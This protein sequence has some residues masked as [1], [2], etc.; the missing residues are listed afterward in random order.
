MTENML[1]NKIKKITPDDEYHY[2]FGYYDLQPYDKSGKYHL[3]HRVKF[4]DR[5]PLDS[6]ICEI[7][8]I[9]I[10]SGRFIKVGETT[11][12]NF[13]QGAFLNWFSDTSVVYN[14]FINGELRAVVKDLNG[15]T[16]KVISRPLASLSEDK[17]WGLSINFARIFSFRPGYG[18]AAAI[19]EYSEENVPKDDG[20][21]IVDMQSGDS[22]LLISYADIVSKYP[23][24]PYTEKKLVINHVTFNPSATKFIMLLRNFPD[25]STNKRTQL[26]VVDFAKNIEKI[27]DY[28]VNSHYSWK[29]DDEFMIWSVLEQGKGVYF[30]NLKT[31]ERLKLGNEIL[32]KD[33]IHCMFSPNRKCFI[34]DSYP[35]VDGYRHIY[36]YNF[37]DGSVEDL[38][39]VKHDEP[40]IGDIRCDLHARFHYDSKT[41]SFDSF[42]GENRAIYQLGLEE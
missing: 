27:T 34:G 31:G 19:D 33:D 40:K 17:K 10:N 23:E 13:Q 25:D 21:Y 14:T 15:E 5:L 41:V 37:I 1:N 22:K 8:V 3:T 18:Y 39:K 26:L 28:Q 30:F 29:N 4:A 24:L 6:D 38:F 12:W 20:V 32:E 2:F 7:G 36:K 42:C 16:I 35:Y 11:A 9:E